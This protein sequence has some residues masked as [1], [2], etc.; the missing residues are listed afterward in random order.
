MVQTH[1]YSDDLVF[2][3]METRNT[4]I[5]SV[6]AS[7]QE[8]RNKFFDNPSLYQ[9]SIDRFSLHKCW[10]PI[11]EAG[12]ND[13]VVRVIKKSDSSE[14][15]QTVNFSALTDSNNLMWDP[16]YFINALNAS[17]TA[18]VLAAGAATAPSWTLANGSWI[19]TLDYST[20][21]GFGND[22]YLTF[23][24]ALFSIFSSAYYSDV[25][26]PSANQEYYRLYTPDI[27]PH[28]NVTN[29]KIELSPIDKILVKS[30]QMPISY[31]FTPDTSGNASS[32][33]ESIVTDFEFGGANTLAVNNINYTATTGQ[34]R[35]HSMNETSSF[36]VADLQFYYTTYNN[37]QFPLYIAPSGSVN[38]KLIFKRV[39][40][41]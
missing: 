4:T 40:Y 15:L 14:Y 38:V 6:H 35:F 39:H 10:L 27:A 22:Y 31:E 12:V 18:A 33:S 37:S 41:E 19:A 8:K 21:A 13:L 3:N 32:N 26:G 28:T 34:Y 29:E 20:P 24:Q 11:F 9:V 36:Q 23:N 17:I 16:Q 2:V 7:L 1:N 25:V 30:N 5:N